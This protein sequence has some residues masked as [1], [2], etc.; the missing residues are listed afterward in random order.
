MEYNKTLYPFT[1]KNVKINGANVHYIDEGRGQVIVFCHPPIAS[2]F[3]YR[4]FVKLLS[5]NCRCIAFDFP[6]FGLSEPPAHKNYS[7]T[8]QADFIEQFIK[9]L[10]LTDIIILG[11]DTGGPSAFKVVIENPTLFKGI[12]LTDTIIFPTIEYPKID[13]MLSVVGSRW[14]QWFNSKTNL[15]VRLTYKFGIMT[16][17]LSAQEKQVYYA[18]FSDSPK[19]TR[20]T[21]VLFSLKQEKE[22]MQSIM[23][24]FESVI[25]KMPMLLLY[26]EKDPVAELGIPHRIQKMVDNAE[27][28]LIKGEGHFPHEGQPEEMCELVSNWLEKYFKL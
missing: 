24:G 27:L 4:E 5:K 28:F 6:G 18:M 3:M 26:G 8:A 19:R 16:R 1:P 14:F 13:R 20:I 2:S 10:N 17:K 23:M 9:V 25:N 11:H 15:I 12:I 21:N 22:F 7:I